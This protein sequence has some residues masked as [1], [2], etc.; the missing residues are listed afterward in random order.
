LSGFA[1]NPDARHFRRNLLEKLRPLP[2]QGIL[3]LNEP[4][5]IAAGSR[6]TVDVTI[7]DRVKAL[8]HN[9]RHRA[10]GLLQCLGGRTNPGQNDLRAERNQ[11]SG[12]LVEAR[13]I[14]GCARATS[15]HAAAPPTSVMNWRRL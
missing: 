7:A 8:C 13:G 3:E 4:S 6:E 1:Q 10:T 14:A 15:G 9:D 5:D 12:V 2:S 11:F